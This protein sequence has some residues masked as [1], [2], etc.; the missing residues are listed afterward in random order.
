MEPT[1]EAL[2]LRKSLRF[3]LRRQVRLTEAER[4]LSLVDQKPSS[5]SKKEGQ[6]RNPWLY[7]SKNSV[8]NKKATMQEVNQE[9]DIVWLRES[10]R[11]SVV[12]PVLQALQI[13]ICKIFTIHNRARS[14]GA[15]LGEIMKI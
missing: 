9:C 11:R 14:G 2:E 4:A 1:G 8:R 15:W 12:E 13:T 5:H 6:L 3:T 7:L 10:G